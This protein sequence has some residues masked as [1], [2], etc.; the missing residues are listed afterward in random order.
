MITMGVARPMSET[1]CETSLKRLW[2]KDFEQELNNFPAA[3]GGDPKLVALF[4]QYPD[5]LG[6]NAAAISGI[7][8]AYKR[9]QARA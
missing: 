9:R 1:Q 3:I 8:A 6:N 2:G 5:T 4:E 7:V